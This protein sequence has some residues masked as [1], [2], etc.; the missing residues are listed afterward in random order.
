MYSLRCTS[1]LADW[2]CCNRV[3]CA[4]PARFPT[5]YANQRG[6]GWSPVTSTS[7]VLVVYVLASFSNGFY[8]VVLS[9]ESQQICGFTSQHLCPVVGTLVWIAMQT[10][11][12]LGFV[13]SIASA[14]VL[15]P[16][17]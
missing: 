15:K 6:F 1:W 13:A 10:G 3:S 12:V 14:P 5:R 11:S 9:A 2:L 17:A 4:D 16:F 7:V 8:T